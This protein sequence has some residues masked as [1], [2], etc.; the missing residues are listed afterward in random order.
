MKNASLSYVGSGRIPSEQGETRSTNEVNYLFSRRL[1]TGF[2]R[3]SSPR[4]LV[5]VG[6]LLRELRRGESDG[7]L[8]AQP[9][10]LAPQQVRSLLDVLDVDE[11]QTARS[12][13][14]G[15]LV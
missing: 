10:A 7:S 12:A 3:S 13:R 4:A 11:V 2:I 14:S 5:K 6:I 15:V 9:I 8:V 1:C